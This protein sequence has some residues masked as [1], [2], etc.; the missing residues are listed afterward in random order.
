MRDVLKQLALGAYAASLAAIGFSTV[1][2]EALAQP[3]MTPQEYLEYR[4]PAFGLEPGD[5]TL[6]ILTKENEAE[7]ITAYAIMRRDRF[8]RRHILG[9][10][11]RYDGEDLCRVFVQGDSPVI[12]TR[13]KIFDIIDHELSHCRTYQLPDFRYYAGHGAIFREVCL[14]SGASYR[15]CRESYK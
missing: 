9:L 15:A 12:N 6:T 5:V 11:V 14:L 3:A 2:A 4:L 10:A 1:A 13:Q 7:N 8:V